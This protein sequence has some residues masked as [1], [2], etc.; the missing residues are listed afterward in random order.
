MVV[1]DLLDQR[2]LLGLRLL[3][4]QDRVGGAVAHP[5]PAELL[6]LLDDARIF[7][8]DVGVERD[9][10]AHAVAFVMISIIRQM[11]TRTP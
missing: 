11:P 2:A 9:R 10:A 4:E 8:A 5:L 6:A 7:A 3:V 1:T